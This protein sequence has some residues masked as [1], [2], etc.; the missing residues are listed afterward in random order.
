MMKELDMKSTEMKD[1]RKYNYQNGAPGIYASGKVT[2]IY[3]A[4]VS[5]MAH[6]L[7]N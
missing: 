4:L 1:L 7:A 5:I 2:K 3:K 6:F